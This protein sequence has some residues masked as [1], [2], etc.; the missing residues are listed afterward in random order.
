MTHLVF[1]TSI[2]QNISTKRVL[3]KNK[4]SGQ[5]DGGAVAYSIVSRADHKFEVDI[6]TGLLTTVDYLDYETKTSYHMNVSATDQAPPFHQ[7]FC[8][9]YVTLLNELDEAVAF[10]SAGYEATLQ[11]NIA[12]GTEVVQVQVRSP[13]NLNQLTYHFDP[14][15]SPAALALFKIDSVTVRA[16]D[17]GSPTRHTDHSLTVNILDV[18]DNAPVLESQRGYNVSINENVGGGTS[19]LRVIATDRDIGPNAM[20]FYYITD[21]NLDMT[22][23]M[24]R[25]TGEMVTRPAPPDRERQQEYR[26]IVAV[27]D[28]GTPPLS[29]STTVYIRIVDENDNAPEFPE[30]EY[31]TVLSEGPDTVGATIATVTAIDPDEGL[32]GTLRYAIIK[33]NLIQTFNINSITGRITAVKE[34]DYEISKGHYALVVTATDQCPNPAL[35]LTSSTT[36]SV[37]VLD[38]NDVTPTFPRSYEG[39]FEVMEGQ[40]GPRVLTLRAI[41]EDSGLNGKVEYSI[42]GGDN[43][44]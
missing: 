36:V 18:N 17:N 9:V 27:E 29:T 34:L 5:S 35:R 44:S 28:D 24:D 15:T 19:V 39:P 12:T 2:F 22:F 32:N 7:V 20:L 41:D 33:G 30:E 8:T 4:K 11:K 21:G 25:M 6:S 38:V 14:D 26:L 13:D 10:F 43:Q 16:T 1:V 42:T 31:V 40:P 37:K 23:R 3:K